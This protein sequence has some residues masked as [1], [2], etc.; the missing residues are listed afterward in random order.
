MMEPRHE[1]Q[2]RDARA[3]ELQA[4]G[5]LTLRAYSEL[6]GVMAPAAWEGLDHAVRRALE[7][8]DEVQRIVAE[9]GGRLVGSAQLWP[10]AADV[11]GGEIA[12]MPW[13]ELR[14]LAVA[15]DAR[16]LGVGRALVAEC[17]ARARR[18]GASALG[19]HTSESM[20]AAIRMYEEM[21]FVRTPEF[22]FQPPGAELVTAYRLEW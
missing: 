1:L 7:A 11:Y 12:G 20:V 22:D 13:P 10:A 8:G 4:I 17:A 19:L 15:P 2:I 16:R 5:D 21:G 18:S 9:H 14:L 6:A 3:E